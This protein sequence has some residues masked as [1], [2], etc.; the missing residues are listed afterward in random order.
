MERPTK[1][2]GVVTGSTLFY[3]LDAQEMSISVDS[4]AWYAWLEKAHSFSFRGDEGTFTA[5]KARAS[6]QRGGWYWYAYCHRD[7]HFFRSYLG[8]SK[9]LTLEHMRDT[10]WQFASQSSARGHDS[11]ISARSRTRLESQTRAVSFR[12]E[13]RLQPHTK[14]EPVSLPYSLSEYAQSALLATKFHIPR[15]PVHHIARSHLQGT[16]DEVVEA[17][18]TLVSAPAGSG[19]TTL[20]AAWARTTTVPVAWLSLEAADDDPQRFLSYVLAAISS[21][22]T[23]VNKPDAVPL[24]I[25]Q[26]DSWEEELTHLVNDLDRM[27]MRDTV[28]IL[29][30]YQLISS[31][32]IHALLRFLI[33]HAPERLHLL[34]GTRSE[35]PLPLVRLRARDQLRELGAEQLRFSPA[36]MQAF[37]RTMGLNLSLETQHH[38]EQQ[39]RGWVVGVHLLA[40]ALRSQRNPTTLLQPLPSVHRFFLEYVSEEIL[41][42]QSDQIR[43]FLL[44]TSILK[45]LTGS[46]CEAVTGVSGGQDQLASLYRRNLLL[47]ML[48]DAGTWYQY[49]PLFAES[50]RIHLLKQEPELV[51]ELYRRASFWYEEQGWYEEACDAAFQAG[52]LPRAAA[53]LADLV[54]ELIVQEQDIQMRRWL[55]QLSPE[56]IVASSQLWFASLWTQCG[57]GGA[58]QLIKQLEQQGR[59]KVRN[60]DLSRTDAPAELSLFQAWAALYQGDLPQTIALVQEA[61][62]AQS[63]PEGRLSHLIAVHQSIVLSTAY[64]ANGD[65]EAAERVLLE[66]TNREATSANHLLALRAQVSLADLYEPW[67]QLHKQD[68]LYQEMFLILDQ[69]GEAALLFLAQAQARSASLLY[70]WNRLKEAE[71]VAQQALELAQRLHLPTAHVSLFCLWVL[72]RIVRALGNDERARYLLEKAEPDL[73][74]LQEL[75]PAN[76]LCALPAQSM[77]ARLA[78]ACGQFE[79]AEHWEK[80]RGLHFDDRLS[81]PLVSSTYVDYVMLTRILL[82]RGRRQRNPVFFTQV[83]LLLDHLGHAIEDLG[84]QRWH[85]ETQML[86]ALTLQAQGKT[87]LALKILGPLLAQAEPEGY[88][89]LFADE[90]Q[91]MAHLL[92]QIAAYTTASSG[93][94]QTLQEAVLLP[95]KTLL[96][97]AESSV[98]R[99]PL[100]DPL[101]RREQ[102]VLQLLAQGFSNQSIAEQ[103]VISLH[104]VKLHVKHILAKLSVTNR[105]QAVVRARELQLL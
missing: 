71:S 83:L 6:N 12:Q 46:L 87:K 8:A 105:T 27:L 70:E 22:N 56:V 63:R 32:P 60:T 2:G 73:R 82:A 36:E 47:Q 55:S 84:Y 30:D 11:S 99:Q 10:L 3:Q 20:L 94:I 54:P 62:H 13:R 25:P 37:L 34:I 102:E 45:R 40:L 98:P 57:G 48:D 68:R 59:G 4:P 65:L 18:L 26:Q 75:E 97:T 91:P 79:Q 29:D 17:R 90:G 33:D 69:L 9:K 41:E 1:S 38:L 50:L 14:R 7:G 103:F 42:H 100:L 74:Q 66:A 77:V 15:L 67:G 81:L 76:L 39:T 85:I 53:L 5:H 88:I 51:P 19:K 86:T 72:V 96:D 61:L 89:R 52:D 31:E 21:L 58:V 92:A 101:S 16:L 23:S 80:T 64:R 93:Y 44:C 104:T 95:L 35:P 43:H 24:Q 49:H 78:L 28:L